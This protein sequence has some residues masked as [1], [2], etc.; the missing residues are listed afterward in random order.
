MVITD[1]ERMGIVS[2]HLFVNEPSKFWIYVARRK[3]SLGFFFVL[4]TWDNLL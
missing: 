4:A 3:M 1:H 2:N